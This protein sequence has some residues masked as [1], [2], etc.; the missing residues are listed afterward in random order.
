MGRRFRVKL[1][2]ENFY[3]IRL[4]SLQIFFHS[5]PSFQLSKKNKCFIL[6]LI[7]HN[8][9][10]SSHRTCCW[11]KKSSLTFLFIG[12]V[13]RAFLSANHYLNYF[14]WWWSNLKNIFF[15]FSGSTGYVSSIQRRADKIRAQGKIVKAKKKVA[16]SWHRG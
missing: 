1:W 10:K 15:L 8:I 6:K 7:S 4:T 3:H 12:R 13:R 9:F 11:L 5:R 14:C 2:R 16:E